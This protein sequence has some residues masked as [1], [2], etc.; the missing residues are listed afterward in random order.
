MDSVE[1]RL[2]L[3]YERWIFPL[4]NLLRKRRHLGGQQCLGRSWKKNGQQ[5]LGQDTGE[6]TISEL[7]TINAAQGWIGKHWGAANGYVGWGWLVP[8]RGKSPGP[9][10]M[11]TGSWLCDNAHVS[12][13]GLDRA[14]REAVW[15]PPERSNKCLHLATYRRSFSLSGFSLSYPSPAQESFSYQKA[16]CCEN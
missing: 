15:T 6:D 8:T 2:W 1:E 12:D 16:Y 3:S 13:C 14:G 10:Q 7:Y 5:E 4:E 9:H 11:V